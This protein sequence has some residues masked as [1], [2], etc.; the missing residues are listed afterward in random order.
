MTAIQTLSRP[1]AP[2]WLRTRV[3]AGDLLIVRGVDAAAR[4][5]EFFDTELRTAF[6]CDAPP[7]AQSSMVPADWQGLAARLRAGYKRDPRAAELMRAMLVD[8]GLGPARTASD[9][10]NLRI[11]PHDDSPGRDER[12]T[13]G[14]HRDTW[15]S[16]VYQQINWWLPVYPVTPGRTIGFFPGYWERAI[17]NDSADWDLDAIRAEVRSARSEG[18]LPV[19]RNTPDPTGPLDDGGLIP[20]VV[21]PG[22]V[23]IFSGAHLHA[24]VPNASGVTRFSLEIRS[25]DLADAVAGAGA[26]NIDGSAPH[27]AWHWFRRL[28]TGD[29]LP[30]TGPAAGDAVTS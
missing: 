25:F 22:D 19:I 13:L 30:A 15:A 18:R 9:A 1:P 11:Q 20:V 23:L 14:A 29:R 10:L 6:A 21:E 4:L 8:F 16:N 12:H 28:D 5:V 17:A 24:S 7:E 27:T 26:P 3:Y 2:D